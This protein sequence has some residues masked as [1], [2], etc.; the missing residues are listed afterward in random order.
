[1]NY[2]TTTA[3]EPA[4]ADITATAFGLWQ[5]DTAA[6]QDTAID[7]IA[8][9]WDRRPWPGPGLATYSV[10]AGLDH[11]TLLHVAQYKDPDAPVLPEHRSWKD[12]VDAAVPG[13]RRL[14]VT[15]CHRH[16]SAVVDPAAEPGCAVLVVREFDK[17]D[18]EQAR[19]LIDTLFHSTADRP[20]AEG[21][22]SAHFYVSLDGSR[23]FN[24]AYWTSEE[25]H[26]AAVEH[27]PDD[28]AANAEWQQ[29]HEW[30]GLVQTTFRRFEFRLRLAA[31]S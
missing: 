8:E 13:L 26:R 5:V 30:P 4:R 12:E 19:Q 11:S 22:I 10:L 28:V 25:A 6:R 29:V 16:R 7:A 20:A 1:M 9:A 15:G 27:V 17:P 21:M 18:V 14:G 24:F 31:A 23:V 3:P 2:R